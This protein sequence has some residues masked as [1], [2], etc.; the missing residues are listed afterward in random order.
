MREETTQPKRITDW[1]RMLPSAL[2]ILI[3]LLIALGVYLLRGHLRDL[4]AYGL[5]GL[6]LVSVL[7]NATLLLPVPGLALV[8]AMGSVYSP[9]AV[10]IVAGVGGALGELTGYAAGRAGAVVIEDRRLYEQVQRYMR[11]YG[12]LTIIVLSIVPNP[13]ID[14]AG[15]ASGALRLPV[16]QFLLACI[17]GKTIKTTLFAFAGAGSIVFLEQLIDRI[18]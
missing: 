15:I 8:F 10:G 7:S 5:P 1:R 18:Q 16:W 4:G 17:V 13:L 11:K 6:F 12:L 3:T 14:L 9:V 2:T